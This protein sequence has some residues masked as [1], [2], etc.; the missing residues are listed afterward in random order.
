MT[1]PEIDSLL[2][3]GDAPGLRRVAAVRPARVLRYLVGRLP[4]ADEDEKLRAVWGIGTVVADATLVSPERALDLARRLVWALRDESG[5]V[6][7]G[8]PEALGELLARRPELRE[9]FLPL[10]C[11]FLSD[12]D[13][14]QTG[15]IE[16]GV[17]WAIARLGPAVP[18]A[19][20]ETLAVVA[21]IAREHEDP[22][23]RAIATR[24]LR[25]LVA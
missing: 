23:T 11:A 16:R 18:P 7:F 10:L 6:P 20:P 9:A 4:S 14:V 2:R 3:S 24:A 13:M 21:R 5:A 19:C 1:E 8:V 15:P 12:P 25:A 17:L 22:E